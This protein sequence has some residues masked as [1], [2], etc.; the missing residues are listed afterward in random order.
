MEV[1]RVPFDKLRDRRR[2]TGFAGSVL[3]PSTSSGTGGEIPASRGLYCALRQAQGPEERYRL[4]GVSA[5]PFDKLRDR[6]RDTG[7]AG[8]LLC[9]S[10]SS[11]TGGEIPASR[12]LS[13]ALRQAQ[14][15]EER[16]RLRGVSAVPFDKLRDRRRDTG[17]AGSLLC[18]STGS[19][20]GGGMPGSL[21]SLWALRQAQGPGEDHRN[22][23]S[24]A[25]RVQV[26]VFP[27]YAA[28]GAAMFTIQA[29]P[30]RSCSMP[31]ES[32]QGATVSGC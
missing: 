25:G 17:F 24:L 14:G 5:V 11:G 26:E 21:G 22:G 13:C 1:P 9:P 18:P 16:Y 4:R 20:T 6:R 23:R 19:G 28:A 30:K 12:G 29:T 27:G 8:S 31:K 32:P 3:C 15:P 10:T 7:F 2:D